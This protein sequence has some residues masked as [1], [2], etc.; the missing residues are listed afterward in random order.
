ML[1]R[2]Q[3]DKTKNGIYT[4]DIVGNGSTYWKITR[5]PDWDN[6][7]NPTDADNGDFVYV[8][9]GTTYAG[10]SWMESYYGSGSGDAI[11]IGVD[12]NFWLNVGGIGIQ[13]PAGSTGAG[14]ALAYYGSFYST[15][16]QTPAAIN[17]A[18][19]ITYNNAPEYNG[20][21]ISNSSR[22]N[23]DHGGTYNIQ[24]SA[25]VISSNASSKNMQIWLKQNGTNIPWT[26]IGRAHV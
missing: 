4:V 13:G 20:V 19:P 9:A 6:H 22:I 23:F 10:T 14:G 1:F 12:D 15:E 21:H 26:K 7:F 8:I 3:V 16:T 17:T 24:F 5:S 11:V 25:Q 2:S 18:Y